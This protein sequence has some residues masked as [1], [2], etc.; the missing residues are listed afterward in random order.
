MSISYDVAKALVAIGA[1]GFVSD[2]PITFKSGII[3][4]IYIDNR[5]FPYYP[6]QWKI[7]LNGFA[8]KIRESGDIEVI[9]GIESAGIPHSATLG[10]M[11]HTPSVFIR[12]AAKDHGAKKMV[13]GGE[14][15]GKK[16]ILVEDLVTLGGSSLHGVAELRKAGAVVEDLLVIVSY[17]FAESKKAFA[18]NKI[19]VLALTDMATIL[20]VAVEMGKLDANTKKIVEE[21]HD[22]PWEWGK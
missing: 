6:D 21:W 12:K 9:A 14:V 13:E 16:V 20:E 22:K 8:E 17:G 1:V 5:C 18:E 10:Y 15:K 3:S 11:T 19:N 4:P 2:K 7:V